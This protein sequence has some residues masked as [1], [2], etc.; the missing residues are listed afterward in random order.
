MKKLKNKKPKISDEALLQW[1][2]ACYQ[3][4]AIPAEERERLAMRALEK[5]KARLEAEKSRLRSGPH[6][7]KEGHRRKQ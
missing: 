2:A 4:M 7:R 1:A 6:K 3:V 5:A